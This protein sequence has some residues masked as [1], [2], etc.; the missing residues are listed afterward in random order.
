VTPPP[1][2]AGFDYQLGEPYQPPAGIGVVSRDRGASPAAGLYNICYVN[3]F[4]TQPDEVAWWQRNHADLLLTRNGRPVV[5]ED[6]NEALLDV[7]TA[8]KRTRLAG[9]VGG[10]IDECAA[11]GFDAIEVDNLDSWTRSRRAL[12]PAHAVEFA[13]LLAAR[14][15][16][17]GLAI[18]QKNAAE[19][20]R[21]G[22][23]QIGF[24]FAIAEECAA[25]DECDA[26]TDHYGANVLAIEYDRSS[27]TE[28][29]EGHGDRLS[30]VLRD[31]DVTAPGSR[32]YV[33][34]SC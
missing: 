29:C 34:G 15:H 31:V 32:S 7:S 13:K 12:T 25:W 18:A 21:T 28:A 27:F 23:T 22:R 3:G 6:W 5:D 1:A 19:L 4:Q 26:Y 11:K 10:W 17:K 33:F 9:I 2:N 16:A 14:A 24:D 8:D 20:S 30:I